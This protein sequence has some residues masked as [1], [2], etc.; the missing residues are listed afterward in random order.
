MKI[1]AFLLA[2]IFLIAGASAAG[3]L[4]PV[5]QGDCAQLI[6]T[7]GNC[8]FVNITTIR[9]SNQTLQVFNQ[10]MTQTSPGSYNYSICSTAGLRELIYMTIKDPDGI[11]ES[12]SVT[13]PI[14]PTGFEQTTAQSIMYF[15]IGMLMFCIFLVS[16]YF[17]ITLPFKNER[18]SETRV[19]RVNYKK[20]GKMFSFIMAYLSFVVLTYFAWNISFGFLYF[21]SMSRFFEALFNMLFRFLWLIILLYI[22]IGFLYY[23]R[24]RKIEKDIRGGLTVRG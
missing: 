2:F 11:R 10:P 14:T 12:Q 4:P 7:C 24:D 8:T 5:K 6:E 9:Y 15:L 1:L 22:F 19:I 16:L 13:I 18:N 3:T 17:T 20:Y 23:F 21:D